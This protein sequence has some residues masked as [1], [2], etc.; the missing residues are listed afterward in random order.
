MRG[1]IEWFLPPCTFIL[2]SMVPEFKLQ[3][4]GL[5][6]RFMKMLFYVAL[7]F[8][9]FL[10]IEVVGVGKRTL[11]KAVHSGPIILSP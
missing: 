1:I 7:S 4:K 5:G 10:F 2:Q 3:K 9:L 8:F 11:S 6:E